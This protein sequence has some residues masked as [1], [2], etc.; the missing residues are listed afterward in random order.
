VCY[1]QTHT[2]YNSAWCV[3]DLRVTVVVVVVFCD[4]HTNRRTMDVAA[5]E[6]AILAIPRALR[7]NGIMFL[8]GFD[9]SMAVV[10]ELISS[11]KDG[12]EHVKS[13]LGLL[14]LGPACLSTAPDV[15]MSDSSLTESQFQLQS[16]VGRFIL[17]H[18]DA[19]VRQS[20]A[21]EK[22]VMTMIATFRLLD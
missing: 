7:V 11:H 20:R 22:I 15:A 9:M 10:S 2:P 8:K 12:P 18:S 4:T 19:V 14:T 16:M 1:L 6:S 21:A 13:V 3:D 17:S 5:L